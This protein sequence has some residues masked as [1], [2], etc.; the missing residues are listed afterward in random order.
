MDHVTLNRD[1]WNATAGDWVAAGERLWSAAAP[2]WGNWNLAEAE[3]AILPDDMGGM[4][5]IELGCG[6]GYVS[7]W[8]ARRG[9]QVTAIDISHAQ[10]A[11]AR[12]LAA[13]N[14]AEIT[15]LEAN[16]EDVPLPDGQF[17]F[18]ISEYGA[19]IW[20]DPKVWLREAWR[21]LR[22]GGRLVFLGSHPLLLVCT[23][24]NGDVTDRRLHRPYRA[25]THN[26]YSDVEIEPGG[27]EFNLPIA[28]WL[29]LFAEIGFA[30]DG[31]REL[32][33]PTPSDEIRAMTSGTWAH[34]YP[35]EQVWKLSKPV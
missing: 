28:D 2:L 11:T 15:F 17:D 25:M 29:R 22:P 30:V 34:D 10:L 20:C 14:R 18:A 19:A 21:L 9:A 26:D 7:G 24:M 32:F 5:A 3:L 13:R 12:K 31:Y 33:A 27:V 4:A 23:P 6:T 1:H 35:S 8:M 16:A